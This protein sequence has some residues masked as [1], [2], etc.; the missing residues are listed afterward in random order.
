V[1]LVVVEVSEPSLAARGRFEASGALS[2]REVVQPQQR[3]TDISPT[4]NSGARVITS[5]WTNVR[6]FIVPDLLC[7]ACRQLILCDHTLALSS[8]Q[9]IS[10]AS[11]PQLGQLNQQALPFT[12]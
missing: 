4:T 5:P 10:S 11:P 12:A 2:E 8:I 7:W 9:L 6:I 3:S 1:R